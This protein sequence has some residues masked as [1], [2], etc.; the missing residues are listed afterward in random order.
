[1]SEHK[2][3]IASFETYIP[4][5]V[6]LKKEEDAALYEPIKAGKWTVAEIIAH[7]MF[8]DRYI[9]DEM[10]PQMYEGVSVKT[11]NNFQVINDPAAAYVKTSGKNGQQLITECIRVREQLV[12][13]LNVKG[14]EDFFAPFTL[15]GE[16]IDAYTGYPHTLFNYIGGFAWHDNHHKEQIKEFLAK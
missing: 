1:M 15:N 3:L 7:I 12:E 4:W 5:L 16:S 6:E 14:K 10:L 13:L 11:E 2:D 9:I 8:W